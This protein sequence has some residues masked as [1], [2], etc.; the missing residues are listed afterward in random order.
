MVT[1]PAALGIVTIAASAE[2]DQ[3][4]TT[5]SYPVDKWTWNAQTLVHEGVYQ[6]SYVNSTSGGLGMTLRVWHVTFTPD[7]G[8]LGHYD[9]RWPVRPLPTHFPLL[10]HAHR[11]DSRRRRDLG[12]VS[13]SD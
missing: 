11:A 3:S 13:V 7:S 5:A 12:A 8:F 4:C 1:A 6:F 9:N 2:P 10:G